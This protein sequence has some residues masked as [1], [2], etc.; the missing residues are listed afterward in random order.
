MS[1][2]QKAASHSDDAAESAAI[3]RSVWL[4]QVRTMAGF[5]DDASMAR[6]IAIPT[7]LIPR[8]R[9]GVRPQW[10]NILALSG[11]L[12]LDPSALT[13]VLWGE[14]PGDP[15]P[16]G[17]GGVKVAPERQ[18]ASKLAVRQRC[19]DCGK[20]GTIY[21]AVGR[22]HKSRCR[23]CSARL[24]CAPKTVVRCVGYDDHG[25]TRHARTC[26]KEQE[27]KPY[28]I[29]RYETYGRPREAWG[30]GVAP[31]RTSQR[32]FVDPERGLFRCKAC[33]LASLGIASTERLL[34]TITKERIR[35]GRHRRELYTDFL[36]VLNPKFGPSGK[37]TGGGKGASLSRTKGHI[38]RYW[39][40]DTLP[41]WII[42]GRCL[43]CG[44]L[45]LCQRSG[46]VK[47]EWHLQCLR[48]WHG[49]PAGR[50]FIAK[51][52]AGEPV[53]RSEFVRKGP[54]KPA[55]PETLARHFA[56]AIQH[57]L[58]SV[59]MEAIASRYGVRKQAVSKAVQSIIDDLPPTERV[60]ARFRKHIDLLREAIPN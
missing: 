29:S 52:R 48:A 57:H 21:R 42:V 34:S 46:E 49:T 37:A 24:R 9:Q 20:A 12:G 45:V 15:C 39:G 59:S 17:C 19:I 14:N 36:P 6:A 43:G 44:K 60:G 22:S 55:E 23:A 32:A 8:W 28:Q 56:W 25:V 4:T 33:V 10:G 13:A 38:V 2:Q 31:T 11:V 51:L 5:P 30:R 40:G 53:R 16:C 50:V 26:R 47:G 41:T 35:S 18:E 27:L 54:G 7:R 58:G 1:L 3:D